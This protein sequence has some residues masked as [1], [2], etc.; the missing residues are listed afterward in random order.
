ME[1]SPL[2]TVCPLS[3]AGSLERVGCSEHGGRASLGLE[4]QWAR[5]GGR[6]RGSWSRC[7]AGSPGG[8]CRGCS[9]AGVVRTKPPDQPH[10]GAGKPRSDPGRGVGAGAGGAMGSCGWSRGGPR[11][12]WGTGRA[13]VAV[14]CSGSSRV[15]FLAAVRLGR[16]TTGA[17]QC[18]RQTPAWTKSPQLS[19][20]PHPRDLSGFFLCSLGGLSTHAFSASGLWGS[21]RATGQGG[22]GCRAG[23]PNPLR[24]G[25]PCSLCG[26]R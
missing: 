18:Q 14:A 4:L 10:L 6:P 2:K 17:V 16:A 26:S 1:D 22:V 5:A 3:L 23:C 12:V 11:G 8:G 25:L 19:P 20:W 21:L 15:E 24:R 9:T 7:A 13:G